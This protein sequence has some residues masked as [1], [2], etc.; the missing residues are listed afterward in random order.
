MHCLTCDYNLEHLSG[1]RCPECGRTFDPA[2]FRTFRCAETQQ[3]SRWT[4]WIILAAFTA[5]PMV[6]MCIGFVVSL[7]VSAFATFLM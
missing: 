3:V 1:R 6:V 7:V 2:D 4:P 5:G